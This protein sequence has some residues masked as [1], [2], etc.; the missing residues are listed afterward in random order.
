MHRLRVLGNGALVEGPL[1]LVT[2]HCRIGVTH[3]GGAGRAFSRRV[4]AQAFFGLFAISLGGWRLGRVL[5]RWGI[6]WWILIGLLLLV[7]DVFSQ[8]HL[9]PRLSLSLL[10]YG[11]SL[12]LLDLLLFL[13]LFF[14]L[15]QLLVY[16]CRN[17]IRWRSLLLLRRPQWD[18]RLQKLG[19]VI[20]QTVRTRR[21]IFGWL[22]RIVILSRNIVG[23]RWEYRR[24]RRRL[25]LLLVAHLLH[26]QSL[27]QLLEL[28]DLLEGCLIGILNRLL[29]WMI[30]Q[31][32][33][34]NTG[35]KWIIVWINVRRGMVWLLEPI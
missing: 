21:T 22:P 27:M 23:W 35:L 34:R 13:K 17:F 2:L 16:I 30:H 18:V 15:N 1:V 14:Q 20:W 29:D 8:L 31:V 12:L 6:G 5:A 19:Q 3:L 25:L 26:Q 10:R 7:D 24:D 28:I 32:G 11:S 4:T 33:A 9:E